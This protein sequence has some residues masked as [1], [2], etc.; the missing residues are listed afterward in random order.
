MKEFTLYVAETTGNA[1][2]NIYETEVQVMCSSKDKGKKTRQV[3][4]TGCIGCG[5]CV[6]NCPEDAILLADNI[7]FI[8]SEKCVKCGICAEK[9][10]QNII[11][12]FEKKV[13]EICVARKAN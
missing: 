10:P 11:H 2:N 9:C 1:K 7:A 13:P 6:K 4:S 12:K 3:C 8:N 5:I